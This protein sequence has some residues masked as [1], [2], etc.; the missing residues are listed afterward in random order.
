MKTDVRKSAF[1]ST[2]S[3]NGQGIQTSF[4][5]MTENAAIH[6]NFEKVNFLAPM[7]RDLEHEDSHDT[8]TFLF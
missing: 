7:T 5:E 8:A 2:H 1:F 3:S 6:P 4:D